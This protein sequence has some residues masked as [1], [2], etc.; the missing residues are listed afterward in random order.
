MRVQ[1]DMLLF[2]LLVP[3][4]SVNIHVDAFSSSKQ[5][6]SS[7][8][9]SNTRL[10]RGRSRT[11]RSIFSTSVNIDRLLS[12]TSLTS[13][14]QSQSRVLSSPRKFSSSVQRK[15]LRRIGIPSLVAGLIGT[16]AFPA[17]AIQV[18]RML[19]D[20]S[21]FHVL[22]VDVQNFLSVF[23]LLYGLFVGQTFTF[24]YAQQEA[25]FYALFQEVTETKSLLEQVALVC[26]GRSTM[27]R[28]LLECISAYIENDLKQVDADPAVS[29]S[30]RPID[31]PLETIM[32][33]TSVGVP[34][35]VYKT[36]RSLRQARAARLGAFQRKV[37]PLHMLL[38][39]ILS[40]TVL[41]TFPLLG[42]ATQSIGD[43]NILTVEGCLF[44]LLMFSVVMTKRVTG[45]LWKTRGGAYNVDAVLGGMV[46]GLED[47][48]QKRI[49]ASAAA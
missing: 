29:I 28:E 9:F 15:T 7:R 19:N 27:Y 35:I 12:N 18:A 43:Y 14:L 37:P 5:A 34:S 39:W 47:E 6:I 26:K 30:A 36:V 4:L 20:R 23:C 10:C 42:A 33:M 31:D 32:Y 3:S 2:V 44:G 16:C 40:G 45:E 22:A 21:V 24:V 25:I 1:S 46:R 8:L 13:S 11:T 48:V 49:I 38:L 41:M 17:L